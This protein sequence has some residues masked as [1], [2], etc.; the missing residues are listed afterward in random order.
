MKAAIIG[1]GNIGMALAEGLISADACKESDIT[2]TRR[3]ASSLTH[4]IEKG[5]NVSTNNAKAIE[6]ADAVF[7]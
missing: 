7:I 3:N 6:N 5:F 1:G 4:L 2:I